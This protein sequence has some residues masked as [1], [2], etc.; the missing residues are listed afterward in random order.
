MK[1]R[2]PV[3]VAFSDFTGGGLQTCNTTADGTT[4]ATDTANW[5]FDLTTSPA[6]ATPEPSTL[7][8]FGSGFLGLLK[9]RRR[10]A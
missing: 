4:C 10:R 6:P 1:W 5:A 9:M 3:P 2:E 8:L 7:I